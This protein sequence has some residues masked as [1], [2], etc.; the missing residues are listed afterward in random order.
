MSRYPGS[1]YYG[2][3]TDWVSDLTSTNSN[4]WG[5]VFKV[6]TPSWNGQTVT[7]PGGYAYMCS[8]CAQN[9]AYRGAVVG[10]VTISVTRSSLGFTA[11]ITVGSVPSGYSV[12]DV[13]MFLGYSYPSNAPGSWKPKPNTS[14]LPPSAS[15][16]T[17]TSSAA[18]PF[19]TGYYVGC[20]LYVALH[21]VSSRPCT[22]QQTPCTGRR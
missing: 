1:Y 22:L 17:V 11:S 15:S 16:F 13:N 8:G 12:F 10:E 5:T 21:Y 6:R 14:A 18:L 4:N 7:T 3:G 2:W 20:T 19:S 9:S